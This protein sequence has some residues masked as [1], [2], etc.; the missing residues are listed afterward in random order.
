MDSKLDSESLIDTSPLARDVFRGCEGQFGN[1]FH[2]CLNVCRLHGKVL[3]GGRVLLVL[4]CVRHVEHDS[5][6]RL[7]WGCFG[8]G[9]S[10]GGNAW[11]N[12]ASTM[13]CGF[14]RG[15]AICTTAT[16]VH[17]CCQIHVWFSFIKQICLYIYT[18]L[19]D[20]CMYIFV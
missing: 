13:L 8:G 3:V 7:F 19:Y 17:T 14:N 12:R 10:F 15:S 18:M 20:F 6:G 9:M 2:V 11:F 5:S 1:V 4:F 16:H